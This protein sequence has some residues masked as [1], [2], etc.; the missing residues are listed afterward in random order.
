M[1]NAA[2]IVIVSLI[3]MWVLSLFLFSKAS[4]SK[5]SR[6]YKSQDAFYGNRY[7][8][9]HAR[10]NDLNYSSRL[11]LN[12]NEE[13]IHL[14]VVKHYRLFH[15]PV[16]IPWNDIIEIIKK[17]EDVSILIGM[18]EH[19]SIITMTHPVFDKLEKTLSLYREKVT[20]EF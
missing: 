10:I 4:W 14:S 3:P 19:R 12:Y 8:K 9:L 2:T 7:G 6:I 18:E 20:A 15:P 5:M 17:E 11:Y 16:F 13:G 1:D